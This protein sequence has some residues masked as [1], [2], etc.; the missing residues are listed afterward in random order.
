MK[1]YGLLIALFSLCFSVSTQAQTLK[2]GHI[3]VEELVNL[4]P[5]RD[6]AYVR[7]QKF[8]NELEETFMGIQNEYQLKMTEYQQKQATWS[9]LILETKSQEL[10]QLAQ[11]LEQFQQSAQEEMAQM[12]NIQF[13]PVYNKAN[14]AIKKV[15]KELG[16][17]Y[18][19]NS[20]GMPYIDENQSSNLLDKVKAEL[21][22]PAAKVAPTPIGN[23]AQR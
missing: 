3:N 7:I 5:E 4:M 8:W 11:R 9:A 10:Q 23:Q 12:Q 14:E 6:S 16:L 19:F 17:I 1:K 2:F 15:G 22:I 18:V 20:A 13:S 21:K